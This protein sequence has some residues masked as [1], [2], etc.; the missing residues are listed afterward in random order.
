MID[1]PAAA[2]SRLG[3][4]ADVRVAADP[5]VD[6]AR[7]GVPVRRRRPPTSTGRGRPTSRPTS[8]SRSPSRFPL[9]YHAE[10]LDDVR[11]PAGR[12]PV[13]CVAARPPRWSRS[14]CCCRPRSAAGG[15]PARAPDPAGG[16]GRRAGRRRSPAASSR[17]ASL[18]AL[19][20]VLAI[21]VREAVLLIGGPS[22]LERRERRSPGAGLVARAPG[23]GSARSWSTALASRSPCAAA[24][25]SSA[26]R[27]AGAAAADRGLVVLG[28]LVTSP[29]CSLFV[30]PALYLRFGAGAAGRRPSRVDT[31]VQFGWTA[32]Q[33]TVMD[34]KRS[35]I[36]WAVAGAWQRWRS[37][38]GAGL[39]AA[40]KS[41]Q[42]TAAD[43]A[44]P[45]ARSSRS[46]AARSSRSRSTEE[47]VGRLGLET[48]ES[49]RRA[50]GGVDVPVL[51]PASTAGR[52]T[53]T[54][55]NTEPAVFVR[56][57]SP[58]TDI[59][60]DQAVLSEGPAAGH[61]VVTRRRCG[62]V[63]RRELGD[64]QA[65][66][67]RASSHDALDRRNEPEVPVHRGR[68]GRGDDVLRRALS[69]RH[70]G[71]RVPRVRAAAG[72]GADALPGPVRRGGR[73]AG[74]RAAGAGAERHRGAR[75]HPLQVG[76]RSCR[77]SS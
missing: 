14:S 46:R 13:A 75:R 23:S 62:A 36:R 19:L 51:G 73:G 37:P 69:S 26:A 64:R 57:P 54:Y 70:A 30:A 50:G 76:R 41:R 72:R 31:E 39:P 28:G 29:C 16:P 61:Q 45:A 58:S 22:D 43:D 7:R 44:K 21:A 56:E 63:R 67:R 42:P 47:A 3:D 49:S 77:R 15:S 32:R 38:A 11:R 52:D 71:R 12:E 60:G 33:D 10:L 17:S 25:R 59:E 2:R 20:A 48:V 35:R 6:P 55:T 34:E 4:V 68:A 53:W 27:R 66:G 74:H 40:P 65:D 9:E 8:S 1:T 5:D 18:A 24:R